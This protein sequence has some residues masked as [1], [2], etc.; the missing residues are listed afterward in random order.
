MDVMEGVW[1]FPSSPLSPARVRYVSGRADGEPSMRS[2]VCN[3]F[4]A[5]LL[6]CFD[7]TLKG[8]AGAVV[9]LGLWVHRTE[10]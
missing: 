7:R 4:I 3:D 8:F 1:G 5:V 10:R 9:R 6:L 2:G